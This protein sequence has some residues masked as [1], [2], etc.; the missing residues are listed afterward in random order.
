MALEWNEKTS[1]KV[2]QEINYNPDQTNKDVETRGDPL[3]QM[4]SNPDI[5]ET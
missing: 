5:T 4:S 3:G 2:W 1:E